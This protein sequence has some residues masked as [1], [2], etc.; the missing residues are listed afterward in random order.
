MPLGDYLIQNHHGHVMPG[1]FLLTKVI[2]VAAPLNFNVV[3]ALVALT[4]ALNVLLWGL[5]FE[6]VSFG[7]VLA[8]LPLAVLALSPVFLGPMM[9]WAC[10]VNALPL[11][12]SLAWMVISGSNWVRH[13]RRRDLIWLGIAFVTGLAFW[14]K[15]IL[16][17]LPAVVTVVALAPGSVRARLRTATAPTAVL[18]VI[19]LPYLVLFRY[20][21]E[22]PGEANNT[23][24]TF[25]GHSLADS[26]TQYAHGFSDMFLPA[27]LGGPWG[28]LQVAADPQSAPSGSATLA[29]LVICTI[30][31]GWLA[32][33]HRHVLW[34]L[35]LP[36]VYALVALGVVLFSTRAGDVLD[37]M[38][39]DRYYVD[40][41]VVAALTAA[42]MIGGV[43]RRSSP[44]APGARWVVISAFVVLGTSLIAANVVAA[45]RVGAHPGRIWLSA[46]R[47]DLAAAGEQHTADR[48]LVLWDAYASDAM[49]LEVLWG[50][51]ARLSRMLRAV[52]PTIA[53]KVAT[54]ELWLVSQQG[55]LG[56]L[57]VER[58]ISGEPGPV[59][60]C[61]YSL[62]PG[63]A[64][65]VP[66]SGSLFFWD[67]AIQVD[68]FSSEEA[69]LVM[70]AGDKQIPISLPAG[71]QSRKVQVEGAIPNK[72][73]LHS[74]SDT[75]TV[76]ITDVF[77][78]SVTPAA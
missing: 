16:L 74:A 41:I 17:V 73:V 53:F 36:V 28:S 5:A 21:S 46:L 32:V 19:A 31:I 27:L 54:D 49:T 77:A 2:T 76:C 66:M 40:P 67:W 4:S 22:R 71:L 63:Q 75:G 56:Q 57:E 24:S 60:G 34:L 33:C 39:I 9:W 37:V 68:S 23:K 78:G 15:S 8:L 25:A 45:Q 61:G 13:R 3:V 47:H 52:G 43:Q 7:S 11:Q 18:I 35:M 48:P 29:V 6:R 14:H 58:S 12:V 70:T 55:Q 59:K 69:E 50:E 62:G 72:I 26:L 65:E 20:L 1:A 10:S 51:D 38:T 30:S 64:I 44:P 42:L